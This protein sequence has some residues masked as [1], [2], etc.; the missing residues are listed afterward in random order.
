MELFCI[1]LGFAE[2][3]PGDGLGIRENGSRNLRREF[4]A[5]FR[6]IH[7]LVGLIAPTR[8]SSFFMTLEVNDGFFLSH[9]WRLKVFT[10]SRALYFSDR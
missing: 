2:F 9:S 10:P 3:W 5:L 4:S 1:F 6:I 7:V 8:Q